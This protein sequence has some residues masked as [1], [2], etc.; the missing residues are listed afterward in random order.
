[1][2]LLVVAVSL[3]QDLYV[4]RLEE[5]SMAHAEA[6]HPPCSEGSNSP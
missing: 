1:M 3:V 2:P 4:R 5:D 6:G